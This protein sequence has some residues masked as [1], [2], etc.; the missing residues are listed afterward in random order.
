M[1]EQRARFPIGISDFRKLREGGFVYVDKT[2]LIDD[3][4]AAGAQVLLTPRPR[5]FGKT[6]NLSMLRC[7]LEKSPEDRSHLFAGLAIAASAAARPHFQ[8]YPVIF[9]SFKDVKPK[10]W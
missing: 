9:M 8:R 5:R 7:F 4:L 3:V 6:L 1:P 10:S 2:G